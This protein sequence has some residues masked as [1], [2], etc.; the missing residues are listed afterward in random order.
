MTS[1][2]DDLAHRWTT[3]D[4]GLRKL[5]DHYNRELTRHALIHAG[6]QP[7]DGEAENIRRILVEPN[8]TEGMRVQLQK[9]FVINGID[10]RELVRDFVSYQTVN[11][12]LQRCLEIEPSTATDT[13]ITK[14]EG[15]DRIF[16]L[17]KRTEQV[18]ENTLIQLERAGEIQIGDI[19]VIVSLGV[20][21][22]NCGEYRDFNELIDHG[23]N[24]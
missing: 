14:N 13:T 23:C 15:I 18:V 20:N 1:I 7:L 10:T 8:V 19:D 5:A 24:C 22:S 21:C 17:Q 4:Q 11:R 9:R 6:I 2:D 12:H 16:A 3:G